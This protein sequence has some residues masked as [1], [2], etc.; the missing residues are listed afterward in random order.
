MPGKQ[1]TVAEDGWKDYWRCKLHKNEFFEDETCETRIAN[2]DEWK[3]GK[4]KLEK[5][6]PVAT[7]DEE[8]FPDEKFRN[9]LLALPEG[10]DGFFTQAEIDSITKID[11]SNQSISDLTGIHTFT[12]LT[13]LVCYENQIS[14]LDLSQ[15]SALEK[16]N[17]SNNLL[18]E[19]DV[20][21]NLSLIHI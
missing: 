4:G 11:C 9:F 17:C 15:N 13:E 21:A 18:T 5:L 12:A 3:T 7:I 14:K 2:L 8:T 19:L 20:S 10:N 1:P 16:L 6:T